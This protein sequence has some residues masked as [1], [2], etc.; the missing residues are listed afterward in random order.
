MQPKVAQL[1]IK[2]GGA[3]KGVFG[4]IKARKHEVNIWISQLQTDFMN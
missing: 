3:T 4:T 2:I 1:T